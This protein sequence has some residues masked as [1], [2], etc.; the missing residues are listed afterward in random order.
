MS[1]ETHIQTAFVAGELAPAMWGRTDHEK[2]KFGASTVRNGYV[3]FQGGYASRAGLAYVGMCKQNA[4]N[5]GGTATSNPPRDI[6]FQFSVTQG[7]VLEFGDQY[8]RIKFHGAYVT[9]VAKTVVS[10]TQA[11]P[12]VVDIMGHGF[13][14]GDWVYG[15][16]QGMTQLNGLTFIVTNKTTNTFQ[17]TDLFGNVINTGNYSAFTFGT[18]SRIYTVVSPY[19]AV[20][21][22]YLKYTQS[23]DEMT[24]TCWNQ[25]TLTGYPQYDLIRSGNTSWAF[26]QT[27]FG[28]T[29]SA[30]TNVAATAQSS[31]TL[32]TWYSYVV[33]TV[34]TNTDE[35]VASTAVYIQNNDI[36][37]NAGS[38]IITWKPVSGAAYYNIYAATP[39]YT[40]SGTAPVQP[41]QNYGY[42]G[43]SLGTS[44]TDTNIIADFTT[45]PPLH[46]NPFAIGIIESVNITGTGSSLT[47]AGLAYSITTSTGSGFVGTP[48]VLNGSLNGFYIANSG[49]NYMA[50]DTITFTQGGATVPTATLTIGSQTGTYPG[51]CA[52]FQ[53]RRG[54]ASTES[55]PDTYYFSH[56]GTFTTFD[57]SVPISASDAIIGSPWAQQVNGIQFMTPMPGGLVIFTGSGAW[58]LSGGQSI[59]LTPADQD[60]QPQTRYGCSSTV[61]PIPVN[62]HIL[63]VREN[64]G[65][66][67]DLV[68]NFFANI[69][70]GTDLTL[71]SS[72][73]FDGYK[74][75]QW[76]YAEKPSKLVWA[77]RNDGTLL[78]MTYIA[79]QQEQGWA[80]HD[81]NGLFIGICSIEEPPVDAVYV[82]TQ[83]FVN[84]VWVYYSERFDNR[85]WVNAED[86]FC[87]DAGLSYPMTEPNATLYP[88]AATGTDNITSTTVSYGGTGYTN[89]KAIAIDSTGVG[90]GATFTVTISGGVITAV[91]PVK[92]GKDY[93][94]G[95]T[96]IVITDPTGSGA[97]IYPVITNYVTFTASASVFNS[98]MVGDIIR[99]GNGKAMIV[100]Y[101]SGTSVIANIIQPITATVPNDPNLTPIPAISG[102]WS[103]S[104]PTQVV[105]GLNHLEGLTVTGLADGGVIEP[106]VVQA[107]G[108]GTVGITLPAQASAINVGLAFLPQLQTLYLEVPTPNSIQTKRKNIPSVG[109][110]IHNTRGISVGNNQPDASTQP[111]Q[112]NVPWTNMIPVKERNQFIIMGEDIPLT[113]G[114]YFINIGPNWRVAGQIAIQQSQPLPCQID[115]IVH[116]YT[117]GDS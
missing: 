1:L 6:Q 83:R 25:T 93:T 116:Y 74:I 99:V 48:I 30:P 16:I 44:F 32:S 45:T 85:I 34:S 3:N 92:N 57:A 4:P 46:Q 43:S 103:I 38:N 94:P 17:L 42:L 63:Y 86:C 67:Y 13:S 60:A 55:N 5:A 59:A 73:L 71:Y 65:I 2:Y 52:Y 75:V 39:Y 76:C 41:G 106:Q 35:S 26:T 23:A 14:N 61:P 53:Q 29:I 77:V 108:D 102:N 7:Y 105:T 15:Q 110:R 8:M 49:E 98:G 88:A 10:I 107:L 40:T 72:H 62:F 21:L 31:T 79:E 64:D 112:V 66:V 78:S 81:T 111:G 69:Y 115:A 22:P 37:V 47:Q 82:I 56:P 104:T 18:F 20:D 89:P 28:S 24:L 11:S 97:V 113:T 19:A 91:T 80:R 109:V 95:E 70:T 100:T 84:G 33:T 114:D 68:F 50:G 117:V 9:E 101:N 36:S 27:T 12:G 54:Y 58:Q 51:V 96:E 87:I 90:T